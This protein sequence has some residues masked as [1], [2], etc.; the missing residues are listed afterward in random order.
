MIFCLENFCMTMLHCHCMI[1]KRICNGGENI[2]D[3]I[4]RTT[5]QMRP[6]LGRR[7]LYAVVCF[8]S[9]CVRCGKHFI[10]NVM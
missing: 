7:K 1:H 6:H 4:L 5:I 8:L 2:F 10:T 9:Y 3:C